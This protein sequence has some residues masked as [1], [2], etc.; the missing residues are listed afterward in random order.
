MS[1]QANSTESEEKL[2]KG[3]WFMFGLCMGMIL[4]A[5]TLDYYGYIKHAKKTDEAVV[6]EFK[7]L[8]LDPKYERKISQK[9]SKKEAFCSSGYLLLK[10]KT[11]KPNGVAGILVDAKNRG[12]TCKKNLT[13]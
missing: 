13:P 11:D 6:A 8:S 9:S 12:I 3:K 1:E 2:D 7:L 5:I 10:P 4:A